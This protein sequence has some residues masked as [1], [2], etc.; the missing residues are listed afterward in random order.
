[1]SKDNKTENFWTFISK[2]LSAEAALADWRLKLGDS[3]NFDKLQRQYLAPTGKMAE[4][5]TCPDQCDLSCGFRK[6]YEWEGKYEAVCR[7][8]RQKEY[9]IEKTDVLFFTVKPS[10]LLPEIVKIFKIIPHIEEFGKEEDTWKL[11][12]VPLSGSK[13]ATVYLT[14]KSWNH[15]IMDLIYRLNCAEHK[16]YILLVTARKVIYGTSE[17]ILNDMGSAFVPL[18]EVLDFNVQ[19]ELELIRECNLAQ[20]VTPSAPAPEPEPENIFRK[21]GDAWEMRFDGGEKF[22][23]TTGN[24]GANYLHFMLERPNTATPVVE[25]MRGISG[26]SE[27]YISID[28]VDMDEFEEGFSLHDAPVTGA[29]NIADETAIR[30]YREEA[31]LISEELGKAKKSGNNSMAEQLQKDLDCLTVA[32]YEAVAPAGQ[33]KKLAN[34]MKRIADAFRKAVIFAIEK[35]Y[36]HDELLAIHFRDTIRYGYNPGYFPEKIVHWHL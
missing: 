19:T 16:P 32:I 31:M 20:L 9:D 24:T 17:K 35:M 22:M 14:L 15:E 34:Q 13:S 10:G 11:G 23:L 6:V 28:R 29:D 30:Q 27:D 4:V 1:M 25:I 2:R 21:C 36:L 18:N 5:I 33:R 3:L 12:V 7:E 26:E 8:R